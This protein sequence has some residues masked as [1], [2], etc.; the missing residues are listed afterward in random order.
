MIPL[1][2]FSI[3]KL[4]TINILNKK[5]ALPFRKGQIIFSLLIFIIQDGRLQPEC[6][7][8]LLYV[9]FVLRAST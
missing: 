2:N 3:N 8:K 6:D 4:L 5:K 9:H 7:D 1:V